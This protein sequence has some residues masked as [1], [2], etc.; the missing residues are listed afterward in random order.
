MEDIAKLDGINPFKNSMSAIFDDYVEAKDFEPY[1]NAVKLQ[2]G[3]KDV[4]EFSTESPRHVD[5]HDLDIDP[6]DQLQYNLRAISMSVSGDE[7]RE[8]YKYV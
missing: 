8:E 1:Y 7:L 4:F 6:C 2:R 5:F 3:C